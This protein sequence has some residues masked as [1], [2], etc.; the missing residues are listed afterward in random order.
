MTA[1]P[2]RHVLGVD[3]PTGRLLGIALERFLEF[4]DALAPPGIADD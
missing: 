2:V 3:E 1:P 4:I